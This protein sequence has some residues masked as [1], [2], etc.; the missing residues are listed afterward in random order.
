MATEWS[1]IRSG[2]RRHLVYETKFDYPE[3]YVDVKQIGVGAQGT[4]W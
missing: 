4:V 3:R 2:Y 1:N